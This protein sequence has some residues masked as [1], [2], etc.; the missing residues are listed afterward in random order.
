L[1]TVG[2]RVDDRFDFRSRE[3]DLLPGERSLYF[4]PGNYEGDEDSFSTAVIFR[5]LAG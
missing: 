5:V 2:R 3:A 1:H 4:F